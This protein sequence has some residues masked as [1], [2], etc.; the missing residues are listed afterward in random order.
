MR[1]KRG[2]IVELHNIT[3]TSDQWGI[4]ETYP[5]LIGEVTELERHRVL[6]LFRS[7]DRCAWFDR[8]MDIRP[9][10]KAA[11]VLLGSKV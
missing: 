9:A 4:S 10:S 2:M 7:I 11:Q 5:H 3:D 1:F 6:I 8:D